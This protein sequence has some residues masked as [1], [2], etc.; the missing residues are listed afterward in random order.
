MTGRQFPTGRDGRVGDLLAN[1]GNQTSPKIIRVSFPSKG[2]SMFNMSTVD[3]VQVDAQVK[4]IADVLFSKF[5]SGAFRNWNDPTQEQLADRL[6][7]SQPAARKLIN[8]KTQLSLA[9]FLEI[10]QALNVDAVDV[11]AT[12]VAMSKGAKKTTKPAKPKAR[13]RKKA[14][15]ATR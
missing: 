6:G 3:R 14:S 7:I 2:Q 13:K 12:A 8:G 1:A 11:L 9:R 4:A 5:K 15:A 10:S